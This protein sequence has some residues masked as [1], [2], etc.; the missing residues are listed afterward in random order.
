ML[1]DWRWKRSQLL[2]NIPVSMKVA[3]WLPLEKCHFCLVMLSSGLKDLSK[4]NFWQPD[5]LARDFNCSLA[6]MFPSADHSHLRCFLHWARTISLFTYL[7]P[8]F[9][10]LFWYRIWSWPATATCTITTQIVLRR[11]TRVS[12]GFHWAV[13]LLSDNSMSAKSNPM[14][15]HPCFSLMTLWGNKIYM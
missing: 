6:K 4:L 14:K 12:D 2:W 11:K 3:G 10:F 5:R 8:W 7:S 15:Y 13:P 1:R 9:I